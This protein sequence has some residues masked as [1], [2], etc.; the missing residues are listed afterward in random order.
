MSKQPIATQ[1]TLAFTREQI[2]LIKQ[3]VARGATDTELQL[4]LYTAKR[5]GLDPLTKQIHAI[6]RWD[7]NAGRETMAIQTGI[8]GYRLIADRTGKLAGI[9]DAIY[10]R[11]D[12]DH[13]EKATVTVYKI[14]ND[15]KCPF[16]ASARWAE[17][18]AFKKDG[19]PMAL[20]KKMPYL[21]LGKCAEALTLRKAF[22]AD[23]TGINTFEE[24][25]Q[26]DNGIEVAKPVIKLSSGGPPDAAPVQETKPKAEQS[27][28]SPQSPVER[29]A[30]ARTVTRKPLKRASEQ[31]NY[32]KL[33]EFLHVGGYT[34]EDFMLIAKKNMWTSEDTRK[35]EDIHDP[36]ITEWLDPKS[37][38]IIM[39]ELE[40]LPR[41]V[42]D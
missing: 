40:K 36:D 17:Y 3:T 37:K 28:G 11:E 1:N 30:P 14:I 35:L 9:D 26:A 32:S 41:H 31:S 18:C 38:E 23:L 4:F 20:W 10:D 25:S 12:R 2:D 34:A 13:P 24:M 22:P 39:E 21:M 6:K 29:I 27:T 33:M 15:E 7:S 8:D 16:T 42:K 19:T 5:V